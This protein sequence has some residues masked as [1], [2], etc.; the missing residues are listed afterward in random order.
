[1]AKSEKH[2]R[3]KPPTVWQVTYS[4]DGAAKAM[5]VDAYH[6]LIGEDGTLSFTDHNHTLL[7]AFAS[8]YW[9]HV[10]KVVPPVPPEQSN[11]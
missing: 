11:A 10:V 8:G 9:D 1:M 3:P 5:F 4:I 2:A 7:Q 6:I